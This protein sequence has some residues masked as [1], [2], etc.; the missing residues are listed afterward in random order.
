MYGSKR[1]EWRFPN[2]I[3]HG[4]A[5]AAGP[6][7]SKHE[8][9]EVIICGIANDDSLCAG[10]QALAH[11]L[12]GKKFRIGTSSRRLHLCNLFIREPQNSLVLFL[13]KLDD[14][15]HISLPFWRPTQH[16]FEDRFYL[17]FGHIGLA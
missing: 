13:H 4:S 14:V 12:Q 2:P 10:A 7:Q 8:C 6:L 3:D 16:P 11:F 15:N 17:V 5:N 9:D 1:A